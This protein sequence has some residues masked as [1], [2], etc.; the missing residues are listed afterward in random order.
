MWDVKY[1]NGIICGNSNVRNIFYYGKTWNLHDKLI[2]R[3]IFLK[4]INLMPK[5]IYNED[6]QSYTDDTTFFGILYYSNSY[7]FLEQIGYFYNTS[8]KRKP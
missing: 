6:Y 1:Q 2:R 5:K 8:P 7:G 3:Q 4:A